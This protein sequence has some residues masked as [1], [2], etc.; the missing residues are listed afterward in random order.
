MK[1]AILGGSFNPVHE[2]H[3]ALAQ[4]AV[5][6]FGYDTIIFVPAFNPPHKNLAK[7]ATDEDRCAMLSLAIARNPSFKI[8]TCEI[9]RGGVSYTIDTVSYILKK[10]KN[11]IEGKVGLIIGEDLVNDFHLWKD[12]DKL[13]T[14]TD[15]LLAF[16]GGVSTATFNFSFDYTLM[17]NALLDVSSQDIRRSISSGKDWRL[18]VSESVFEYITKKNLYA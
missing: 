10:Y 15:I 16:R 18:H 6:K 8:D 7:G 14:I 12:V 2:G 9:D 11:Q 5:D 3:I 13:V 17:E 1:L 4:T